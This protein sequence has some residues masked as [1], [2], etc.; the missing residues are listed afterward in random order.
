MERLSC[1]L[2]SGVTTGGIYGLRTHFILQH[3]LSINRGAGK[4]G[5]IC[6]Q[7][8]CQRSY[9]HFF[10][11]K[12]HIENDHLNDRQDQAFNLPNEINVD[13]VFQNQDL[14]N[15]E[16]LNL[17]PAAEIENDVDDFASFQTFIAR[18]IGRFHCNPSVT[19]AT[20]TTFLDECE[21]YT[22]HLT[23]FFK[24]RLSNRVRQ[25]GLLTEEQTADL[26]TIF[27]IESPFDNV[28]TL[29]QQM[30]V[31]KKQCGYIDSI[32][33]P[34]GYRFDTRLDRQ[35]CTYIPKMVL[36]TCQYVPIIE[37][38]TMVLSN[39][40][41][42]DAVMN[43][44]SS[45]PGVLS[46]FRDGQHFKTHPLFSRYPNAL[47]LKL[48]YDE[49]EIVNALGSKTG[50]H[51]LGNFYF[52]ID[53]LPD[54]M[55]SELTSIH[56]LVICCDADVR[57]YD[58]KK[59]LDPFLHDLKCLES[60]EGVTVTLH[61]E[62]FVLRASISAFCG[63]GLAVHQVFNLL[64]PSANQFCRSCMYDRN[65]LHRASTEPATERDENLFN[66]H[67]AFLEEHHYSAQAM[68]LTGVRGDSCLNESRFFHI[69]RNKIFDV[70]HDL[71]QGVCPMVLKLVLH[72]FVVLRKK[73]DIQTFNGRIGAFNY[74]YVERKN[75]PSANFTTAML[76]KKEHSLSQKGAQMWLLTRAFPFLVSGL[77][78][79]EDKFLQYVILLLRIMELVL[80]PKLTVSLMPYLKALVREFLVTFKELF[81]RV[82]PIN[83]FH[84][85]DHYPECI[86]WSGPISKYNCARFEGKHGELKLRA[87]NVHNFINPPKTVIRVSQCTQ[88]S[89]WGA[90]DVKLH[91]F[92]ALNGS[93][94]KVEDTVS[95]NELTTLGYAGDDV[96]FCSSS[97]QV[98]G[99]AYRTGLYVCL[100][101]KTNRVD[102]LPLFGR[103]TEIIRVLDQNIYLRTVVC[104]TNYFDPDVNAYCIENDTDIIRFTKVCDLG[105]FTPFSCWTHP[106]SE[107]LFISLRYI[108]I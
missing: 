29:D 10:S 85:F 38:L 36:D 91:K 35:S 50:I 77:V 46:S 83:K 60:D 56:A 86:T 87:Q 21:Q 18:M 92:H 59:I 16:V 63:D 61:G 37:V 58:F 79:P 40:A 25:M 57:K 68:T 52:Q 12:R 53:N 49:L 48:Y 104:S 19:G 84:N 74:G 7:N 90:G 13:H 105:H 45:P 89:K 9:K 15:E 11:L 33:I 4:N 66:Q 5:F 20:V 43:E 75:K 65:S 99:T 27:D 81:P 102:N 71:F 103:I 80:A 51:K 72:E 100:E 62:P 106:S 28:K 64:S 78:D 32:E 98:D 3:G 93:S 17:N 101:T 108:L 44:Q 42:L 69:A 6:G 96:V 2:C 41:V 8:N 73:F 34:L 97:F 94:I 26:L 82:N 70:F 95:R 76:K 54:H 23:E 107:D 67:L 39:R 24:N 22:E 1:F 47:R 88:S 31:L 55:N 14:G 30:E